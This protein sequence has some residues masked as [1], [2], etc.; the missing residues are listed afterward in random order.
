M[1]VRCGTLMLAL[2]VAVPSASAEEKPAHEGVEFFEKKI[3]PLLVKHCYECHSA[4]AKKLKGDLRLDTRDGALKGGINGPAIVPGEPA[5]SL[6]IK[7]VRQTDAA[8]KMPPKGKLSAEEIADLE[9]WVK[10][11]APD[12]RTASSR[13]RQAWREADFWSLQPVRDPLVPTV[14]DDAWPLTSIDRFILAKLEA[15]GPEA[16]RADGQAHADPPRHLRPDRPAADARGDRRVPQATSRPTPSRRSSIGCSPRRPT[17]S[18]GAGTGS[19]SS[20]TPTPP[21]TTPTTRSRRC[22]ATATGSSTRSTATCRTTSSSAS[23]SPA[24]C[25][26]ASDEADRHDKLIATGYL[27]NA[28]RFGSYED[29]RYPWHLTIEDTIDNLGR[30]FLGLTIS[31]CRCHD[32]KFDPLTQ[33][34]L[35]RPVRLLPAARA[36]PGPASSWTRCSATSCRSRRPTRSQPSRRSVARRLADLDAKIKQLE[37][38]KTAADKRSRTRRRSR[39]RRDESDDRRSARSESKDL[40]KLIK[41]LARERERLTE[42]PLPFETAYAV[43]EGKT[44]GKQ[45]GRQRLR[46]DQGRSGTARAG[47]AAPL[48]A[49]PRRPDA[50][51][52]RRRAAAGCELAELARPTRRIR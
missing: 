41:K 51:A 11:G 38:D 6:L 35:L 31:C 25:L 23:S 28:R 8:L 14:N 36:I 43:A 13:R 49:R 37:T 12:P 5:K 3:R 48:P 20:A 45:Q 52:E 30:T 50:A 10:M 27:A 15:E 34:G 17:A 18:A 39:R 32:H 21:A 46:A 1:V 33:R 9:A 19:T 29:A 22:T 47:S 44:E 7:A 24:T 26:P 2:V 16:R 4:D 40:Y 42:K